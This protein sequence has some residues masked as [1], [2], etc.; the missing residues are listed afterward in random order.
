MAPQVRRASADLSERLHDE[1]YRFSFF[2]AVR[3]AELIARDDLR[4]PCGSVGRDSPPEA[5]AV[6]FRTQPSLAFPGSQVTRVEL[7]NGEGGDKLSPLEMV[8]SFL[9]LIGPN[10]VLPHHYTALLLWR[11]IREKDNSLRDW[12][13]VFQHRIVSQ[14]YRAWEK[15]RLPFAF[16]RFRAEARPRR[17]S[18]GEGSG[19]FTFPSPPTATPNAPTAARPEQAD[20]PITRGVYCLVGLGTGGLRGRLTVPDAAF[21]YYAGQFAHQPRNATSLRGLLED[22]FGLPTEV[23]TLQGQWLVLGEEDTARIAGRGGRN[24][25]P[26]QTL[27]VGRRVWD[28]QSKFRL[29]VGPL[30]YQQFRQL[31]PSGEGL[32][33]LCQL[34]RMYVGPELDFDVQPVLWAREVPACRLGRAGERSRLG[35]N[36]W[37][38]SRAMRRDVDDA[39]FSLGEL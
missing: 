11:T 26:G 22:Y 32:R 19:V 33:P 14:F 2:Q 37:V 4:R 9:G 6:H 7:P 15:Y 13:D 35:W 17:G 29:R 27:I 38:H 36:T 24:N 39:V 25:Q 12:L 16:E 30:S 5:E 28:V 34:T 8:V 20:D 23:R 18:T 31:M 1:P 21:L 3:L 10:G